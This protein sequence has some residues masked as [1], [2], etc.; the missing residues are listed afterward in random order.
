MKRIITLV[1]SVALTLLVSL[2]GCQQTKPEQPTALSAEDTAAIGQTIDSCIQAYLARDLDRHMS[3]YATNALFSE[4]DKYYSGASE[5]R[6]KHVKPE[7]EEGTVSIY[8]S[9]DRVVRGRNGIAYVSERNI[10]ESQSKDGKRF[11]TDSARASYVLEKQVDGSWKFV[12][13][14][15][16]GPMNWPEQKGEKAAAKKK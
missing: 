8:K 15:W 3:Y 10:I 11:S 12:Q 4:Y 1:F 2:I 9:A 14:H 6:E 13:L 16:S 5:I 7:F